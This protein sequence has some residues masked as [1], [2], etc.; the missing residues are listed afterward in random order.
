MEVAALVRG[1]LAEDIGDG[2]VTT[3]ATVSP[4]TRGLARIRQKAPGAIFGLDVAEAVF[5]ELDPDAEISRQVQEGVWREQGGPVLEVRAGAAALLSAERT[6]L[7]FLARLSGVA[8]MAA[9]AAREVEGTGARVLDTRKTTPGLRMLEKAAVAAGGGV[10]HRIGLFDAIL[11]KE[12]HIAAAGGIAE[13][14]A[15]A[16]AGAPELAGSLEVEVRDEGE[17][18]EALA[19]GAPR[20]LLDNMSPAQLR[21]AVALVAGRAELEASGGVDLQTL[22]TVAETGVEWI[23]MGA[24]T[25]SAPA[26][27][28]SLTLEMLP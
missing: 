2:D 13:A 22:R 28:L 11:I 25:H 4:E 24:L 23:S 20:L 8:T 12:N 10:N 21:S 14:V 9:R 5:V 27:D 6:A 26:L 17:I 15:R 19:A 16:R 3:A 7:N 1:A 18:E